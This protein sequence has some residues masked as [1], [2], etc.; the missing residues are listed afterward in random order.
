MRQ[1]ATQPLRSRS[2]KRV[3]GIV[4]TAF[5]PRGHKHIPGL[6]V[7]EAGRHPV[8]EDM[9]NESLGRPLVHLHTCNDA[10]KRYVGAHT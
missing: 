10:K 8:L 6:S 5:Y 1:R 9:L 3:G 4:S 2:S 7:G